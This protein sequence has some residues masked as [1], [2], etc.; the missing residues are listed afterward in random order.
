MPLSSFLAIVLASL[1]TFQSVLA[2]FP[3]P[4]LERSLLR[5]R[6]TGDCRAN[7]SDCALADAISSQCLSVIKYDPNTLEPVNTT[8]ENAQLVRNCICGGD[9]W[10]ALNACENCLSS[11]KA[12]PSPLPTTR[13]P[14][15]NQSTAYCATGVA[16]RTRTAG[17]NAYRDSVLL[18]NFPKPTATN[19]AAYYTDATATNSHSSG[20]YTFPSTAGTAPT[21][22]S[23]GPTA[24]AQSTAGAGR[25]IDSKGTFERMTESLV[26]GL[27]V[28][29]CGLLF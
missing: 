22:T 5:G 13:L 26:W 1:A 29:L 11:A 7:T 6:A 8:P 16:N 3:A 23:V 14:L 4:F 21:L 28:P 19:F 12:L 9:Y 27:F 2:F 10:I 24:T 20:T 25:V 17:I 15:Y 18:S